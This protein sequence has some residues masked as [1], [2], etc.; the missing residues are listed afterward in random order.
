MLDKSDE[1]MIWSDDAQAQAASWSWM[2]KMFQVVSA[3]VW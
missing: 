2:F 1:D 3:Q